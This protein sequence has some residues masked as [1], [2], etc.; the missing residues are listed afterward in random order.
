MTTSLITTDSEKEWIGQLSKVPKVL[1]IDDEPLIL[2]SI[3]FLSRS[4]FME[5]RSCLTGLDGLMTFEQDAFDGVLLDL[6]LPDSRGEDVFKRIR[7]INREVPVGI[8]SGFITQESTDEMI[9]YGRF[10][11]LP[12]PFDEKLADLRGWFRALGIKNTNK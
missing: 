1:L 4:F 7:Q 6:R 8:I 10:T 11:L 12:K 9:K 3:A 5:L 2:K